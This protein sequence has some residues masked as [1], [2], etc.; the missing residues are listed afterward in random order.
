MRPDSP[1]S[2]HHEV[3]GVNEIV[4][5]GASLAGL[6]ACQNL[7]RANFEGTLT[8]VGAEEHLPYD[9]PPLSKTMLSTEQDPGELSLISDS[10]LAELNLN[11]VLGSPATRLDTV[12]HEVTVGD[13]RIFYDGLIIA[14]GA[15]ARKL[16]KSDDIGGIHTLRTME[17]SLAIRSALESSSSVVIVGA[18]FIGSEVAAAAR[19]R[20]CQVSIIEAGEAPL[21]RGLGHEVGS[22]CGQLHQSHGVDLRVGV[23]IQ[24][25]H[26]SQTVEE[27]ELTDGSRIGADLVVVG[28]GATP[29]TEWLDDSGLTIDDGVVCDA[30]LNVGMPG[31][32]AAGDVARVPNHWMGGGP[33]RTEHWT[34]A[35]E[36]AAL[37]AKNL[38]QPA[39]CTPYDS[40]PFVWSDQY[41]DRI[42]I[43]GDT[44]D[45]DEVC[46]LMG[47]REAEAFVV[48]Y[49]K[50]E[51]LAGVMA[52]NSMRPFVQYRRLLMARGQW[53]QALDLA[54]ELSG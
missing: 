22:A 45:F 16:L 12:T 7:R 26:G 51:R 4:V 1:V 24:N 23:Q 18:G 42:Q 34:T 48:G 40:V 32:Y 25:F 13:E 9:R 35:T 19:H 6:R 50:G 30:N 8:L 14:T 27:V 37:A 31:I 46:F 3:M 2:F 53:N 17:D 20:G 39:D 21:M 15:R 33:L 44:G 29:N 38:L 49:R 10:D 43:A 41:E 36:H 54:Q 52:L 11:L 47:S 28:V 5:V